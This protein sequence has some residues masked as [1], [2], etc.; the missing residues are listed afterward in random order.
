MSMYPLEA[1]EAEAA[2]AA[3]MNASGQYQDHYQ[4]L[5]AGLGSPGG[6]PL[7]AAGPDEEQPDVGE[8]VSVT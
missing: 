2:F 1:G 7:E 8:Q 4:S 5:I 3:G 6:D